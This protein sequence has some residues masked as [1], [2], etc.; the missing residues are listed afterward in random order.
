[1]SDF[2][3]WHNHT[4]YS[5]LDGA[6]RIPDLVRRAKELGMSHLAVSDH[7]NLYG[8]IDFYKE[9]KKQG[10]EPILGSEFYHAD[11]RTVRESV[12][13]ADEE[14]MI[15][16]SNKRYYH[17]SV[18]ARNNDGYKNLIKL[19]SDAYLQG[20]YYKP[21]TDNNVLSQH[22]EGLIVG[23]GCLGGE[24]LQKLMHHNFDGALQA[25]ADLQEIV[26]RENMFVEI[27]DHGLPE[28]I[29]TN[30]QLVEIARR[31]NAPLMATMDSHYVHKHDAL[32]HDALLCCQTR[33]KISDT[34]RFKFHNEE[35]YLK[36]A[37]EMRYIFS[38]LPEACDN[39]VRMAEGVNV[40]LDFSAMH[41]PFYAPPEG[42]ETPL[43]YLTHLSQ[44]GL[45][46][47]YGSVSE[48]AKERL[49]Y[50]LGVID[51]LGLA[52]YFLI[53]WDL[54]KFA[55]REGI[56]RGPARGSAAGSLVAYCMDITKVD[57]LR[58]GLLFERF[59]NPSR[60]ALPDIDLDFDTRYRDKLIAYTIRKYGNDRVAQIITFSRIRARAAVRDAARVLGY[61]ASVG[62]KV[63]KAMPG[64][65][66]GE[67]TP[68][69]YCFELNPRYEIGYNNAEDLRQMYDAD[70]DV[71]QI[72]DVAK[73]LEDLVRQDSVH[74][75]AVVITPTQLTDYVPIQKKPKG[76]VTTQYEKNT[77]EDLGL[78]KMDYLGLRNLDVIS[79]TLEIIGHD[80]GIDNFTFD[81]FDTFQLLR[82]GNTIGVFQLES[83]PMQA[84]LRRMQ[85]TSI[86]DIAAVVALYRPGPMASNMHN[87]YADRKNGRNTVSY[88]HED[89]EP[90]LN[91][92]QGLM[93]YQE[94]IMEIVKRFAGYS[95]VEADGIRK[96]IG[97]KLMD[98]MIAEREKFTKG[99][100]AQGYSEEL[101]KE[102]FDMIEAFA[103]YSFNKCISGDTV[104]S[105][106]GSNRYNKEWT[107]AEI[108]DRVYNVLPPT[109][110]GRFKGPKYDGPCIKCDRTEAP[111][112]TRG[113]C[114]GCNAWRQKFMA[115]KFKVLARNKDG[116]IRPM[117]VKDVHQNGIKPVYEIVLRNGMS[118]KATANHRHMMS[119]GRWRRV[120]H[121]SIGDSLM[122]HAGADEQSGMS[123]A[124]LRTTV[125]ER[126]LVGSIAG[127]FGENNCGYVDGGFTEWKQN[128]SLLPQECQN[129]PSH[130]GRLEVAHLDGNR[131]NNS[132]DNLRRLCVSCHKKHDYRFNNRRKAWDKGHLSASSEI[133]SIE[134]VGEEMTYDLEMATE[135]HCFVANGIVTHNSHAYSYAYISYQT[136]FLKAHYPAE[137]MAALCSSVSDKI[138]K[139]SVF[140]NEAR[141]MGLDVRTPNINESN[142]Y[143]TA[144]AGSILTGLAAVKNIGPDFAEVIVEQRKKDGP[145]ESLIDFVQRIR[146]KSNQA[147][148]LALAGALDDFGSRLGL[149]SVIKDVINQTRKV[150][151]K[152]QDGQGSLFNNNDQWTIDIPE[153]EYQSLQRLEYERQA[154][155]IYVSGHP[156]DD[157]MKHKTNTTLSELENLD[158]DT[159]VEVLVHL[160][161]VEPRY[162]RAGQKMATIEFSDQ[163][164]YAKGPCF[165]YAF[166]SGTFQQGSIGVLGLKVGTDYE[167]ERKYIIQSFAPINTLEEEEM[168]DSYISF[169]LPQGFA[170]DDAAISKLKGVLLSYHGK[171]GVLLYVSP[172]TKLQLPDGIAV[173]PSDALVDDVRNLFKEF[174]SR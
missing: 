29:A 81:D 58:H 87:E 72:V 36:S 174:A 94:Q 118:L 133:V 27:M 39:T 14:G 150:S 124:A 20:Y 100:L 78:L 56:R 24:V 88:F 152:V 74:A 80:P 15:D 98:K 2:V 138:E 32:N 17:L 129:N 171:T 61:D 49:A 31:L 3:S 73:G 48:E 13:Q 102:L 140:M 79:E 110:A 104:V 1:M 22:S 9:C 66:M 167:G 99:C 91:E 113:L 90:Y 151:K 53:V 5:I 141:N 37:E 84:L 156:I 132:I 165:P 168:L 106:G 4:S 119:D 51:L 101:A 11:D 82:E 35:Y 158:L 114:P 33:K 95:L 42:F 59:L 86:D 126:Q 103:A 135:E 43:A 146:P 77:I 47:R 109:P 70:D 125:G 173:E 131:T 134:Y 18:Y 63:A 21:R 161:S 54:V 7:G 6:S 26:G 52:S 164:G 67:S 122:V 97:K 96:I 123:L 162:T 10:I 62:D 65:V 75:A 105:T 64:L 111:Y 145:Y 28:Q 130:I 76:V 45:E 143:F 57:P 157:Y 108:Y 44:K 12:G 166:K 169:Y 139:A 107:V 34:N 121:L 60:I 160:I 147:E 120:D 170:Q 116:R 30:P 136:A 115:G 38:T 153:A 142:V 50:E 85:P 19:S 127:A 40:T 144:A 16:G 172:S 92:T 8:L 155:G 137:Y 159:K 83:P 163:T 25:A 128:S 154:I 112:M 41:L 71:K 55:D 23:T 46:K 117:P 69:E 148:S 93:I 68:L 89:A 149:H